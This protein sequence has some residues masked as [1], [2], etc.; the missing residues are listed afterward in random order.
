MVLFSNT[1]FTSIAMN[2]HHTSGVTTQ[3]NPNFT[4]NPREQTSGHSLRGQRQSSMHFS[5]P[6]ARFRL[7]PKI[8]W[9]DCMNGWGERLPIHLSLHL[10]NTTTQHPLRNTIHPPT[11]PEIAALF[12]CLTTEITVKTQTDRRGCEI[13][14]QLEL[15]ATSGCPKG[16]PSR[17]PTDRQRGVEQAIRSDRGAVDIY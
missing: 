6:S 3:N 12:P 13:F 14:R 8:D 10:L 15:C 17:R 16:A 2:Q 1:D 5:V 4:Y 9:N 11:H 7:I